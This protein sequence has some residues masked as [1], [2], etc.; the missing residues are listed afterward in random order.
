MPTVFPNTPGVQINEV[1]L[2]APPI[3]GA[4]TSVAGFVGAAPKTGRFTNTPRLVTS[5]DQFSA[6]YVLADP[7]VAGDT[8]ATRS[9]PLSRG[10]Y[11]FFD[12]GGTQCYV[13]NVDAGDGN[14]IVA[15]LKQ[16]ETLHDISIIA[17]PGHTEAPI[18]QEL[19]DQCFRTGNRV[20]ILDPHPVAD[21]TTGGAPDLSRLITNAA[22]G[23]VRPPDSIYAAYYYP[24]IVVAPQP[25]L[26]DDPAL[27]AV[28]PSGHIA[29]VYASID[30]SRGVHKAPANQ[31]V[32]G[33]LDV[34]QRLVDADQNALNV[35]G[36]NLLRVFPEGVVVW[37]ARTLQTAS[38][39]LDT[40]YQYIN[41][42]R[43]VIYVE[44][45]LKAGLRWATFEPNTL[46][47]RQQIT[48][49]TRAFLD[50]VW[51][52]GALFGA[53][54]DDAYYV[55]FPELFNSDADRAAGR[56]TL[57]IGLRVTF[58]AEFIV[59]RIGIILQSPNS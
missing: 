56:L 2:V 48:R 22:G 40:T 18:Y 19:E 38:S 45:S 24:R 17:V 55:R 54:A 47:L 1:R 32:R 57:E 13:L 10:V 46:A 49:S 5:A 21:I 52:D 58:P 43:L 51:R 23:G 20:A 15:G 31:A 8:S 14:A 35:D 4:S 39:P 44:E 7:T 50:G 26:R 59:V 37:G 34:E 33:A 36:V 3:Q 41:V 30:G 25:G 16:L 11:G 9:T 6:N 53:T 42:R 28:G 27:E 12:N 29:G